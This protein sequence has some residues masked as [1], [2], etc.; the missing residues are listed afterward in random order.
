M[1]A[2]RRSTILTI[3]LALLL[4][5]YTAGLLNAL[6]ILAGGQE[7]NPEI[8]RLESLPAYSIVFALGDVSALAALRWKKLGLQGLLVTILFSGILYLL[9]GPPFPINGWTFPAI[10]LIVAVF[11]FL[12]IGLSRKQFF[13]TF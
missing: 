3:M 8:W 7:L 2:T 1:I 6:I 12:L 13:T 4:I 11:S 9:F 10:L 5:V